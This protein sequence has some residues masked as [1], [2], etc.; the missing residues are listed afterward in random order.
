MRR[1]GIKGGKETKEDRKG[2]RKGRGG[3]KEKEEE[4]K[5]GIANM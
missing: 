2:R 1:K 4:T 5:G 3:G